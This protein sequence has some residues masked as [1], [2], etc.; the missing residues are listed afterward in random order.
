MSIIIGTRGSRLALAQAKEVERLLREVAPETTTELRIIKTQGD[1]RLDLRL[2]A[3]GDKGLFTSELDQALR[4]GEIDIAVHSLKDVPTTLGEGTQFGALL[5][6]QDPAD[7]LIGSSL[8]A[9][10]QGARVGTSSPRRAAQLLE[11]RPDLDI[12]PIRGNVETRLGKVL[13]GEYHALVMAMAGLKRLGLEDEIAQRLEPREMVSAPGQG[14]IAVQMRQ[15]EE[16]LKALLER[17][18]CP[19]TALAVELERALLSGIGGGCAIPLGCLCVPC[20]ESEC[21]QLYLYYQHAG[22]G[23]RLERTFEARE[24]SS[25][26]EQI[27]SELQTRIAILR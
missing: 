16:A 9:L 20:Q 14:A 3:S 6:R 22:Q 2:D 5:P 25:I 15:G 21:Y 26:A 12:Q 17:I 1:L 18:H 23:I 24:A 8:D 19:R 11:L 27:L 13:T 10:P 7:A 4:R